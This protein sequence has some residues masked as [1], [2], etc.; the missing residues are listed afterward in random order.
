MNR[1]VVTTNLQQQCKLIS[2]LLNLKKLIRSYKSI[3]GKVGGGGETRAP[4]TNT[5]P[6]FAVM[7]NFAEL[8]QKLYDFKV[9]LSTGHMQSRSSIVIR[10]GHVHARQPVPVRRKRSIVSKQTDKWT[11][12]TRNS[13]ANLDRALISPLAAPNSKLTIS[14]PFDSYF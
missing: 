7:W 4:G 1:G 2:E 10:L 8:Q 13:D 3:T 11:G 5:L 9:T 14:A 12:K 6:I